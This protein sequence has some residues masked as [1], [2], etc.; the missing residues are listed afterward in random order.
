MLEFWVKTISKLTHYSITPPLHL[1]IPI[2]PL[3]QYSH[4]PWFQFSITP[5][6]HIFSI[7][8]HQFNVIRY[9]RLLIER[10]KWSVVA[11]VDEETLVR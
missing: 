11:D 1:F 6:I 2:T 4:T 3:F 7:S 9:P 5:F 10:V 8:L